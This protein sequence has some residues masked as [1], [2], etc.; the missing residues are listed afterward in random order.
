MVLPTELAPLAIVPVALNWP[1]NGV[2]TINASGRPDTVSGPRAMLKL[3]SALVRSCDTGFCGLPDRLRGA[4]ASSASRIAV[5][6]I[7]AGAS[8]VEVPVNGCSG[9]T[10]TNA[11]RPCCSGAVDGDSRFKSAL[12]PIKAMT[13][14]KAPT[15]MVRMFTPAL[16]P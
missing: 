1:V 10:A 4:C 13:T 7:A 2:T 8:T 6:A 12:A 3:R 15:R 14:T 11:G 16:R 9:G 5:S